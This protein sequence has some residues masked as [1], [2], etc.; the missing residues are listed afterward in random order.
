MSSLLEQKEQQERLRE[1]A[2]LGDIREVRKLVD[3]GVDVNSQNGVNG[4]FKYGT[5]SKTSDTCQ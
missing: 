2:A 4:C 5:L 1:A 3:S